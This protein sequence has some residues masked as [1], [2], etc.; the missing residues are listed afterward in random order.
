MLLL[1]AEKAL[2]QLL[3]R[4]P[5]DLEAIDE[6]GWVKRLKSNQQLSY[7]LDVEGARKTN[8]EGL[9]LTQRAMTLPGWEDTRIYFRFWNARTDHIKILTYENAT[10]EAIETARQYQND[11]AASTYDEEPAASQISPG[12]LCETGG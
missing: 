9:A 1:E 11:L 10:E 7:Q 3:E 2:D 8:Q 12:L 4:N 6:M 5:D